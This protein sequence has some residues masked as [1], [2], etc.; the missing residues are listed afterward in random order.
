MR[1]D[2]DDQSIG[3]AWYWAPLVFVKH[4][5]SC[6]TRPLLENMFDNQYLV[7]LL[8]SSN[9]KM[10][11]AGVPQERPDSN[12]LRRKIRF[13]C[14]LKVM[15]SDMILK[16]C[17]TKLTGATLLRMCT[18][19]RNCLPGVQLVSTKARKPKSVWAPVRRA[20]VSYT[21]ACL[22]MLIAIYCK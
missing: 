1:T 16:L 22:D 11:M 10:V 4:L 12:I 19:A 3:K 21:P 2:V 15:E 17:N 6:K 5:Q 14:F 13:I 20:Q 7:I 8:I 9:M 18:A